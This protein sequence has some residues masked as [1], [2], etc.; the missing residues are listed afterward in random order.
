ME[1]VECCII[2]H[3]MMV[4]ER[5]ARDEQENLSWYECTNDNE[6]DNDSNDNEDD[7]TETFNDPDLE[8]VE[9]REAE[10][11]LHHCLKLEFYDG[12]AVNLYAQQRAHDTQWNTIRMQAANHRWD[13]LYDREGHFKLRDAIISQLVMNRN[14]NGDE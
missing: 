13:H 6:D 12:P 1:V 2:L 9:R 11:A 5:V 10:L 7:N 14:D 8:Y 3:N 4:S